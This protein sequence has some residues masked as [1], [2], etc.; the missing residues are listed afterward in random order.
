MP[1][2]RE[3]TRDALAASE[4]DGREA[5][6]LLD[7]I[8]R[9]ARRRRVSPVWVVPPVLATVAVFVLVVGRRPPTPPER[10]AP[11]PRGVHLYLRASNEPEAHAMQLDLET[12]GEH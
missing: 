1:T 5:R 8:R 12:R 10:G 2:L 11:A 6:E 7:E 3:H 9:R 4:P